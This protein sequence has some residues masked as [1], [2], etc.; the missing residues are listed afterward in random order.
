M[1]PSSTHSA[2]AGTR[3]SLRDAFHHRQR[4]F[5]QGG[6]QCEVVG[7]QP[8]HRGKVIDRMRADHKSDR[9]RLAGRG[10]RLIDR[11]Q[12]ARRIQIDAGLGAAAQ[13]QAADADIGEAG[14]RIDHEIG[15]RRDVG[16][17]VGAVLQM[18]G[19]AV[20]SASSP[21][22]TTC[23]A[24]ASARETSTISGLL[25]MRRWI[26]RNSSFGATPKARAMRERLPVTL[27]T[28]SCALRPGRLEHARRAD[29]LPAPP[30]RRR[31]RWRPLRRSSSSAGSASTKRRSRNRSKS[32]AAAVAERLGLVDDVHD[33]GLLAA[34][35]SEKG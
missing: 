34:D 19:Q 31:D 35:Y 26:S 2:S 4:S 10:A 30:P 21:V 7:R 16:R 15:R 23:C 3:T 28:S 8:H 18:H 20:R 1:K 25:R 27:P 14:L 24:G 11:A 33:C 13:H 12:I 17:A 5:A 22:S 9:H 29:C 32:A 6:H